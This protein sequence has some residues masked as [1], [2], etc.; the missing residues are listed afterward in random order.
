V[1]ITIRKYNKD[2]FLTQAQ[3]P[4]GGS[5]PCRYSESQVMGTLTSQ[6]IAHP[7]AKAGEEQA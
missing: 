5:A 1:C 2:V 4:S 3:A 6:H 7:I